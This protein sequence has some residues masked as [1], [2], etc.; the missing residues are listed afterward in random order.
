MDFLRR[1]CSRSILL[2]LTS[3][4]LLLF[5]GIV[6][7]AAPQDNK[8]Q[9]KPAP[10]AQPVSAVDDEDIPDSLLHPRWKI[11]KIAPL[12]V[13]D[14]DSSALDLKMPDNIRQTVEYDDSLNLYLIGSKIGDTYL[15]APVIMTPEEYQKWSERRALHDFFRQKDAENVKTEGKD[16]FSFADM[17][18][19]LGPAEKIFGPGGV[20]IKTQGTAEL[21]LGAT[22]KNIDNPSLPIRNRKTTS[23][24]F[25]EKINLNVNGKVGDKVNMNLNYNTDAT[26]DFDTQNMKLKYDGKEDE[27]IKLVEGG[28]VSFPSNNSLVKGASSLFG[29][30][31]DMQF[32]KLK[33]QTVV[34]QKKSATKS[35]SAKG[36]T[37]TTAFELNAADYEENRHF[38]LSHYFREHY[39][40]AMST[41]PNL[42]TG[43][44][45]NR[46]EVWIT[47]K[48][49]TTSNTRNIIA[50]TDL[51]ENTR[52]SNHHWALT[53]E[54]VPCN[55]AN[56]EYQTIV[57]Q[58]A[59][60]RDIDQ[61]STVLAGIQDFEG[62]VD[63]EKLSSARLLNSS[64]Y[65]V[66]KALGYISLKTGLQTD[67]VL[68]V[69][70][71]FTAGGQTF[72]VGEFASDNTQTG[73]ALFVKTL[74]NTSNNPTQGNWDL[75][76]KNV[77]YLASTVER[78]KFRLDIKYQSDTAGVYL[79]YIP[80]QRVKEQ[81]LLRML[82]CDRLDNN[83][84][85]HSNGY[86][87]FVEGYTVS[88]GRV[89]LPSAEPFGD[90]L[91]GQLTAKGLSDAEADKYV[92]SQLYD[93]TK[94]VAKQVAEKNK[95]V[96]TGQY[97]GR[98]ANVIS[99][100]A[101]Y[102]PQGSV[103]VTA[104][105]VTLQ[106]GSDYSV[107]YNA[108]EVTILNQSIIDAGTNV[109]VS[110][111]SNTEYGMQRKTML[112]LNWEYDFTKNFQI[113][114][115]IMHLSEQA[116]ISKVQMGEEPL[117]NTIW[118]LNV[119]WKQ[120]SQWLT[121]M[122]NKIPLLHVKDPS[123]ITFTGEFAHLIAG[124]ASGTQ[125]NASYIDDFE[126]TKNYIPVGEPKQW[127]ISSVPTM[128]RE[129]SDK[130]GVTSGYNRALLSWYNIDPIFTRH[131]STL[132]PSH[133][134]SDLEQLS[135]HYVRE[136]YVKELYPNR[137]QSTYS[138]ATSTLSVLNLA[139]YPE[140]RGPY[141]LTTDLNN[142]GTLRQPETK[143][144]G[145]MRKLETTDFEQANIE[146]IE[147]WMLDPY[148][149]L[150]EQGNA[151]DYSGDLYFNLGEVSEDILR[152]G[153]KFY[154]SGMP[155]DGTNSFTNTQWGRIP[156]QATQT[157]AFATT[158]GSRALQDVGLNGLNDEQEREFG[159]YKEWLDALGGIVTNDSILQ[160]W[161]NDPANDNYHYYR[162]SDF[163]NEQ[164][165]ILDRYKRINNPQG[166]SP[167][168]DDRT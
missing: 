164:K 96:M 13:E 132:T 27:I 109:N 19:D 88:N 111:E 15:N 51:G 102:V 128:F 148:I 46:V 110:L 47:N 76:M 151:S 134:K 23:F 85:N 40:Q 142:D 41:L 120:D 135:N 122:L 56:T 86:F 5:F 95:Y 84:K 162:G 81:T 7:I 30:R 70:Y 100:D 36:G 157:Y 73:Q 116:L 49:G 92:F 61:A 9:K 141:N 78:T 62:G 133:I 91:R 79:T 14:L 60:A 3:Y 143:W 156:I 66:N 125:D 4:L 168:T 160:A 65:T 154:E 6:A 105:G 147:F 55:A 129:S 146:Y 21:K 113:G 58:Y 136:V 163:D 1:F 121:S 152:D 54:M 64:E 83:N 114:G 59:D 57:S 155:V 144:G 53:G 161:R 50:L 158:S 90:Y 16:K 149:Y 67:Q 52:V 44:E 25:D 159:A 89:F 127:T 99:L 33:L 118:G 22:M 68:A 20:R 137:Q 103:V 138:G 101:G 17:H 39:D 126:N 71:E 115:T 31:T 43:I 8:T 45:I 98:S 29:I 119:N 34:S 38:F 87:D 18:F 104:G 80:D 167:D 35:V 2:P 123:H 106:E 145:M 24:D 28:N 11:Q 112:G 108:G 97:K 166:N 69:A 131:S 12:L 74:K 32:G 165:S 117:R 72:Q 130:T 48:T 124:S 37:Q 153:K 94:T 140:E 63:Y 26:F 77:Y 10:K 42:T 93:S 139:Y 75:M 150:R 82:G 107:D